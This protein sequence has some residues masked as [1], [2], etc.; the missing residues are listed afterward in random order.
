[1]QTLGYC[2][3]YCPKYVIIVLTT[4]AYLLIFIILPFVIK[5]F[6]LSIFVWPLY[7][8]FTVTVIVCILPEG[9][10]LCNVSFVVVF[11]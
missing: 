4:Y 11:L 8:G 2:G 10:Q 1:M 5:I 6:I 3:K 7:T 9:V